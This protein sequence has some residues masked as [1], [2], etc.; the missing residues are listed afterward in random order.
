M[1]FY[2]S[3]AEEEPIKKWENFSLKTKL[4]EGMRD[5]LGYIVKHVAFLCVGLGKLK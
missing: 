1:L 2:C 4:K 5:F 3:R